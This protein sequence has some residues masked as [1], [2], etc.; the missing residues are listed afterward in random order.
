MKVFTLFF[1]EADYILIKYFM[2]TIL[3][4]H[5]I[6]NIL[7]VKKFHMNRQ[8]SR[9]IFHYVKKLLVCEYDQV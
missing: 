9:V 4:N 7:F 1:C 6:Y 8:L 2:F 3:E 5:E